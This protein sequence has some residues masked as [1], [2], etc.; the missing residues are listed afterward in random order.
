LGSSRAQCAVT[1]VHRSVVPRQLRARPR[2]MARDGP[3][4]H[5]SPTPA[6]F[7]RLNVKNVR[8]CSNVR[9]V[10]FGSF[11]VLDERGRLPYLTY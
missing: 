3:C 10:R 5:Q 2:G 7:E 8:E 6:P 4:L 11:P 1:D 9:N